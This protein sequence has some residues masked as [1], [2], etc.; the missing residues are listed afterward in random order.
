M[1]GGKHLPGDY[2]NERKLLLFISEQVVTRT[3]RTG[4]RLEIDKKRKAQAKEKSCKKKKTNITSRA[5]E[6]IEGTNE[7]DISEYL[8]SGDET[9]SPIILKYNTVRSYVS[10]INELWAHQ[11]SRGLHAAPRPQGVA[12]AAL[13]Q[14]LI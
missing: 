8:S 6:E 13:K 9:S 7:E 5:N 4:R 2:V 3:S 12:L 10:A 11:T 1:P 14:S